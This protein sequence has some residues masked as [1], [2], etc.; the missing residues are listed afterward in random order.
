MSTTLPNGVVIYDAADNLT[1]VHTTLAVLAGS[2]SD[3]IGGSGSG[4]RQPQIFTVADATARGNLS[5]TIAPLTLTEGDIADQRDTDVLYRWSGSAWV[6]TPRNPHAEYTY[7]VSVANAASAVVGT[8][9]LVAGSSS[10]DVG[11]FFTT[12]SGTITVTRAG[13][14][15]VTMTTVFPSGATATGRTFLQVAANSVTYR[16][17]IPSGNSEDNGN[18]HATFAIGASGVATFTIVQTS[19]ATRVMTGRINITYLGPLG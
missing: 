15:S 17:S 16:A 12:G 3:A 2:L 6:P 14:Y 10:S 5:T 19:G 11:S 13:T 8:L 9:T 4:V 1:P 7:S 18:V